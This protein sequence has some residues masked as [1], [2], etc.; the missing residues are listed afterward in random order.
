MEKGFW[1][2]PL[3]LTPVIEFDTESGEVAAV[4]AWDHGYDRSKLGH[5]VVRSPKKAKC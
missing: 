2:S 3:G 1:S 5:Y 4:V